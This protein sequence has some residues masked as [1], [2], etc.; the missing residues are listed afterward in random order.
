M[1]SPL[2]AVEVLPFSGLEPFFQIL[3][4]VTFLIVIAMFLWTFILFTRGVRS[5]RQMARHEEVNPELFE[6][7]FFVPALN[8]EVTIADSVS[9]L[10]AIEVDRKRIVVINDGSDDGTSEI[11][12]GMTN[13]SLVVLERKPPQARQGKAAALNYAFEEI[14]SRFKLDPQLT[15]FC[16]VDADGRIAPDSLR[17]VAQH[18]MDPKVGGVQTL[19]RIYNRHRLLTWFQDIEFSIYGRLFQAGRNKWGTSGMGGN[20]QY[21]RMA[22]LQAIDDRDPGPAE[23]AYPENDPEDPVIAPE[24]A[25]RGPWRDRLTEDQDLGLRLLVAGWR[26][27]HDNRATVSQQGVSDLR[28]LFRQR[29]RWSQGNLQAIGLIGEIGTSRL[30]LPARLEQVLFLLMPFWQFIVGAS[31]FASIYLL[32]FEDVPFVI[33]GDAWWWLYFLYLL[34]FGGTVMGSIAAKIGDRTTILGIIKGVITGQI[35]AFYTWLLWPVLLRS[36]FRQITS[37]E[38]WAKTSREAIDPPDSDPPPPVEAPAA[39]P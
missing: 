30:F 22:A 3:F 15:I 5:D 8:E 17:C 31:L 26:C 37:R 19:V 2:I 33:E 38:S 34:G 29:T 36:A 23:P 10:E 12:A 14:N 1:V 11:L 25:S 6:W 7:I 18:F 20:G 21:N 9:R 28:R 35:Y 32:L 24:P 13:P 16:I 27:H 4:T 39:A